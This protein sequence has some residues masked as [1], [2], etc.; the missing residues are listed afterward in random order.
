MGDVQNFWVALCEN[1]KSQKILEPLD[2]TDVSCLSECF[3]GVLW[4]DPSNWAGVPIDTNTGSVIW[5]VRNEWK[6]AEF[7]PPAVRPSIKLY[8]ADLL[9]GPQKELERRFVNAALSADLGDDTMMEAAPQEEEADRCSNNGDEHGDEDVGMDPAEAQ[10]P[11]G[12]ESKEAVDT[13][14]PPADGE[15]VKHNAQAMEEIKSFIE[16]SWFHELRL[17]VLRYFDELQRQQA[18]EQPDTKEGPDTLDDWSDPD[19]SADEYEDADGHERKET[20]AERKQ[21]RVRQHL[22]E[23]WSFPKVPGRRQPPGPVDL[24]FMKA[25]IQ[26]F[27]LEDYLTDQVYALRDRLCQKMKMSSFGKGITYESPNFPIIV[28]DAICPRCCVA[29]NVDVTSHPYKG[30]GL[31]TCLNCKSHYEKDVMEAQLVGIMNSLVEAWQAQEVR[32]TSCYRIRTCKLQTFCECYGVFKLRYSADDFRLIFRILQSLVGPH[33]LQWL[34]QV[35]S[36]YEPLV[37]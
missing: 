14:I 1:V 25:L 28:R 29:C 4:L 31:W 36:M 32:C 18:E 33:D 7:L 17:R 8:A 12:G 35:L 9:S 23:K 37:S 2:L 30:P 26:I 20:A 11:A 13:A 19:E 6:L 3:Y 21:R 34:G 16:G 24:E 5:K 15:T 10:P 22:L 27:Q